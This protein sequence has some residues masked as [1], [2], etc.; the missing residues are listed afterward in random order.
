MGNK[1]GSLE[2]ETSDIESSNTILIG[3]SIR[4]NFEGVENYIW[5]IVVAP[6]SIVRTLENNIYWIKRQPRLR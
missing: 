3:N 1:W 4:L 5:S 2:K 6:T